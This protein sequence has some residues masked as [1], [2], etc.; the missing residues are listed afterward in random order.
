MSEPDPKELTSP[1]TVPPEDE[2]ERAKQAAEREAE[3][4]ETPDTN[5]EGDA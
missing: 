5:F 1:H 2:P 4:R 3:S